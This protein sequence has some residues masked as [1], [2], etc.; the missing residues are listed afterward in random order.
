MQKAD[1]TRKSLARDGRHQE[2]T[3]SVQVAVRRADPDPGPAD[4]RRDRGGTVVVGGPREPAGAAAATTV[5]RAEGQA[6]EASENPVQSADHRKFFFKF[7]FRGRRGRLAILR[8]V[9][10]TLTK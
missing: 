8:G 5:F 7:D 6:P 3:G 10:R 4:Q 9:T 2:P 1:E